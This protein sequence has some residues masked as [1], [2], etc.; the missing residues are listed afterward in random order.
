MTS[1]YDCGEGR[2]LA[3]MRGCFIQ[4]MSKRWPMAVAVWSINHKRLPF[5]ELTPKVDHMNGDLGRWR[6]QKW[7]MGEREWSQWRVRG[8]PEKNQGRRSDESRRRVREE[9]KESHRGSKKKTT[10][11]PTHWQSEVEW[12]RGSSKYCH[13]NEGIGASKSANSYTPRRRG[14]PTWTI[15]GKEIYKWMDEVNRKQLSN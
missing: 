7:V 14:F 15:D 1:L 2:C 6:G 10:N 12:S 9:S 3:L 13:H 4:S 8:E 5:L 11:R